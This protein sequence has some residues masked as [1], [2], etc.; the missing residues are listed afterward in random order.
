MN[1]QKK[2][3]LNVRDGVGTVAGTA[4]G[5]V[6]LVVWMAWAGNR[7]L[8]AEKQAIEMIGQAMKEKRG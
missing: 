7:R 3:R 6:A 1:L 5:L 2:R 8:R 4:L